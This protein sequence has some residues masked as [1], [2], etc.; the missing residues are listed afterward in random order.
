MLAEHP[1]VQFHFTPTRSSWLNQVEL[2]FARIQRD[3]N[4]RGVFRFGGRCWQQASQVH[5]RRFRISQAIPPD[6][7]RSFPPHHR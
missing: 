3:I 1:R 5:P 7:H 6:L 2:R 4:A